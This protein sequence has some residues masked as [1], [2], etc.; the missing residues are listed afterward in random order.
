MRNE[1]CVGCSYYSAAQQYHADRN[2][3]ITHATLPDGHF[4]I[5]LNPELEKAVD[6]AMELC[7]RGKMDA[8]WAQ[9]TQLLREHPENHMVCYAMGVLHA[10]KGEYEE[11]IK[12]FDKAISTYPYFVEAHFNKAVSYQKQFKIAQAVYAYRK[13]VELGDPNDAPARQARSFLDDIAVAI[14]RNEGVDL[15]SYI[16]SQHMFDHAFTLLEQRDWSGALIGFRASAAKNDC[17]APIHGNLGLCL[18]ALGYKAQSLAE[19]DRALAIDPQYEPA[20]TNRVLVELME[21]G[22]PLNA[23]GFTRIEFGKT[24]FLD[25]IGG[26][27]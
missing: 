12:W 16:E 17:N 3:R 20:R 7:E 27:Q 10:V 25:R 15:D 2:Q 19:L 9:V 21:E 22:I 8:A 11:S 4:L 26:K 1:I 6:S 18:A 13:V 23:A 5:E 24:Q 14:R